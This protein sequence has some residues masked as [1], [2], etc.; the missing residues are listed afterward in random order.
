M[1]RQFRN[2]LPAARTIAVIGLALAGAFAA[3]AQADFKPAP[4]ALTT[5]PLA[6]G[7]YWLEGGRSNTGFIV[8]DKGVVV[9]DAQMTLDQARAQ[10]AE[11]GKVTSKPVNT[12][13]LTHGDPD[14]V[15]GAPSYPAGTV[16]IAQE[17]TRSQIVA[18]AADP[19]GG[20]ANGLL[21]RSLLNYLPQHTVSGTETVVLNGV[22]MELTYIAPAHSSGDLF[23]YLPDQKIVF[24]GDIITTNTG[25]YPIIHYDTGGSSRGWIATV[26]AMLALDADTFVPGHG[27]IETRAML[28]ARLRDAEQRREQIKIL[29][30]QNKTLDEVKAALPE[31]PNPLPFLTYVETTYLELSKGYPAAAAP[32]L[33]LRKK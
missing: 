17:N 32:W 31:A 21:F 20:P 9:I 33:N 14:H 22:R 8:G 23:V 18:A 19:T 28:Q 29:V 6:G 25:Q 7:A 27:P 4:F 12:L 5:H 2:T 13:V 24:A 1:T 16:I 10:I 15:G 26:K 3:P 30:Q 11:I